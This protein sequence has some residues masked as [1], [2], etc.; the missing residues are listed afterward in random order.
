MEGLEGKSV[1][2]TGGASGI[3]RATALMLGKA[4]CKVTVADLKPEAGHGVVREIEEAGGEAQFVRTDANLEV[5]AHNM[6]EAVIS[7][8]GRLDGACNAAGVQSCSK[9]V[10][11]MSAEEWDRCHNLN[12]RGLFFCN[13]HEIAAM[14]QTGGGS[15]VNIASSGALAAFPNG[16][17]YCAS[18]AGVLGFVRAAALDYAT[19]GIRINAVLPGGTLTPMLAEAMATDPGLEPAIAAVHPMNRFGQPSEIA[20]GICWLLSD[21]ASFVTGVSLPVDGGHT[22]V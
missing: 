12:M 8:Y 10:H 13:K 19:K 9:L 21:G 15:I 7:R 17:E 3:G 20:S 22:A 18:K 4:G 14:L 11:E 2:V 16:S 6:V 1:V 5:D